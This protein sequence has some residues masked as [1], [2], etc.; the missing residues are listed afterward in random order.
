MKNIKRIALLLLTIVIISAFFIYKTASNSGSAYFKQFSAFRQE[1]HDEWNL[2]LINSD[3][4]LPKSYSVELTTLSNG[5]K[6]DKRIYPELQQMFSDARKQGINPTVREGYRTW[7][8][9]KDIMDSRI[10]RYISQGFKKSIA[11]AKA[12]NEVAKPGTSEHESGLAVDINA[13]ENSSSEDVYQWLA[14]NAH[15][16]GF[17]LRYPSGKEKITGIE[18]EPWHYRYVGKADAE[19]IYCENLTLEEYL[20]R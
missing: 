9:Q 12:E 5:T 4:P 11:K 13:C 6:V 3:H 14:E 8:E 17:I 18:Y 15:K 2:M 1:K 10:E 7:D 16:Y 19:K 20:S